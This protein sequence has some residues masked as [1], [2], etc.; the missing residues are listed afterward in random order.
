MTDLQELRNLLAEMGLETTL[1]E[2]EVISGIFKELLDYLGD[3]L[4]EDVFFVD[5][6][7][8]QTT[9]EKLEIIDELKKRSIGVS[10]GDYKILADIFRLMYES[11]NDGID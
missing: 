10:F 7:D 4:E 2:A 6:L 9:N 8:T 1:E 5:N 11:I 3:K